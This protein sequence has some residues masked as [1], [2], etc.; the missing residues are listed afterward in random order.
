MNLIILYSVLILGAAAA[1]AAMILFLVAK[2]FKVEEDPRIDEVLELLPGA[3]CG[4]CG[5]A[6]CRGL[7]EAL[8]KAA[9]LGDISALH[10]PPGGNDTMAEVAKHL[11]LEAAEALPTIA[12]IRCGGTHEKAPAKLKYDGPARC[13]ISHTLFAGENGCPYGCLGLGDCVV[14]CKFDAIHIDRETGL[15]LVDEEK[16]VACGACVKSCPRDIIELRPKGRKGRRV[17]V[18]CMNKEKGAV[19]M[20][21]CKAACIGCGKCVKECP[22]K[23]QAFILKDNLAYIDPDKCIACGKCISVCPTGAILATFTPPKPKSKPQPKPKPESQE[24]CQ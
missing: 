16:C 4:G 11:G 24:V 19:A 21:K 10:C 18:N 15:P 7:A 17:W 3:N 1:G 22:E 6:G 2:K 23:V 13:I 14:S 20:K 9:D 12:V 8:V 5:F